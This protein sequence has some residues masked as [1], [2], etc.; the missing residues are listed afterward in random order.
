LKSAIL[1]SF[2]L[3]ATSLFAQNANSPF[4]SYEQAIPG[5]NQKFKMQPI[6]AG[7]FIMGSPANEIKRDADEGPQKKLQLDAFWMGAYEVTRD[8]F[9]VFLKDDQTSMNSDMDAITRPS[10]QYVDLSWGMGKE[11]GYPANS[12]SQRAALMYCRWLYQK[13]EYS[14]GYLQKLSGNMLAE[15]ELPP[16]TFLETIKAN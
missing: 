16:L 5:S 11:G 7:A 15:Q 6:P 9:D 14:T 3:A 12:M 1:F 10:P 2:V 4:V 8:Q 13:R